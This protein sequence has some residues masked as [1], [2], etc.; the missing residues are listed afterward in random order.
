M[1]MVYTTLCITN[2]PLNIVKSGVVQLS[3]GDHALVYMTRKAQYDRC[4]ARIIEAR[5]MKNF[6][7][8]EFLE[9]L[10]QKAWNESSNLEKNLSGRK[11]RTM[12]IR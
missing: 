6:N 3:I 12:A 9:D 11:R 8:S 7:E 5:C 4:G 10:K 2:W 1:F